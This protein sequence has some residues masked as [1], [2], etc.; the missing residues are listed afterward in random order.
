MAQESSREV[1]CAKCSEP[2]RRSIA[3]EPAVV[4]QPSPSCGATPIVVALELKSHVE[5]RSLIEVKARHAGRGRPSIEGRT[6]ASLHRET[7]TW[8]Q[9]SRVIDR[10][11]DRYTE[12]IADHTGVIVRDVD[13]SLSD[14]RGH[15]SDVGPKVH[16]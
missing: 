7:D 15:G 11:G 5:I 6:G 3:G 2:R 1:R 9:I 4:R 10:D 8:S 12:R 16:P 14:H 13:A